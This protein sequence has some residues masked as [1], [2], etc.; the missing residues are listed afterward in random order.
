MN[1]VVE[2]AQKGI[3]CLISSVLQNMNMSTSPWLDKRGHNL[4]KP[5]RNMPHMG[6]GFVHTLYFVEAA[7]PLHSGRGLKTRTTGTMT[8]GTFAKRKVRRLQSQRTVET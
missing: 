2:N 3:V 4:A 8:K 7:S 6:C 5:E 1:S